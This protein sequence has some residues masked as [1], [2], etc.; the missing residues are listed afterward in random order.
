MLNIP[1]QESA[2]LAHKVILVTG[3]GAGIGEQIAVDCAKRG[4]Q[5]ILLGRT[6]GKLERTYDL[7]TEEQEKIQQAM[8]V[9]YEPAIY[10]LDL[11]GA[12][13]TDYKELAEI[14]QKQYKC[15]D[16]LVHN[17]AIL[18]NLSPLK[19]Y[20]PQQWYKVIQT[21]LNAVFML[22]QACTEI[23]EKSTNASVI[24]TSTGVAEEPQAFWG[25]YAISKAASDYFMKIMAI[26]NQDISNIR[27]NSFSPG[28]VATRMR[29]NAFPGEKPCS[30]PQT[31]DIAPYYAQLL[32]D[33][34]KHI[35]GEII[36]KEDFTDAPPI[37][38]CC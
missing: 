33:H 13:D 5:V 36:T 26:E 19:M 12:N 7:I 37:E 24:F 35:N 32:S 15:L 6:V 9:Y 29:A 4:A 22:T 27:A 2:T 20:V 11:A 17:A 21:N 14:I 1:F 30:I 10:P 23:L 38:T 3:A 18:G 34:T 16:G 8:G 31:H 28:A 25:A